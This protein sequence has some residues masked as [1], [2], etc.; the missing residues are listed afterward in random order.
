MSSK[1]QGCM[2]AQADGHGIVVLDVPL[3]FEKQL[4]GTVDAVVVASCPPDVQRARVLAR[5]GMTEAK[6]ESILAKQ[7]RCCPRSAC[8]MSA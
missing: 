4:A 6:F 8:V 2:Q 3:L 7:A 5:P 1:G